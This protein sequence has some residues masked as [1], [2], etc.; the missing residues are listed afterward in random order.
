ML[1]AVFGIDCI[2]LVKFHGV[3]YLSLKNQYGN[4]LNATTT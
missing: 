4:Y 2:Y 3:Y 1:R